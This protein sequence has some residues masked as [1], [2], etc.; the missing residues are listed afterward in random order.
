MYALTGL[1]MLFWLAANSECR[2]AH[3]Q[4]I[5]RCRA[6]LQP[7]QPGNGKC[8]RVTTE[9]ALTPYDA[10]PERRR[11]VNVVQIH[12]GVGVPII[13]KQKLEDSVLQA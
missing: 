6:A 5:N 7:F 13:K 2:S 1:C 12:D 11:M 4:K 9:N 8:C 10:V 3:P